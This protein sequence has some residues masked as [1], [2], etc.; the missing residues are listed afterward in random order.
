M[1]ANPDAL[2]RTYKVLL[3]A[4]PSSWRTQHGDELLGVL[5]DVAHSQDRERPRVKELA[6]LLVNGLLARVMLVV[7]TIPLNRRSRVAA[8]ATVVGAAA[9]ASMM[10]LGEV[11]R[12]FRW[13][14]YEGAGLFDPFTTAA[15]L[16]YLLTLAAFLATL[17][18]QPRIRIAAHLLTMTTCLA[19][20]WITEWT[21]TMVAPE[22][23][24]PVFFAATSALSL[25]ADPN[26]LRTGASA[27]VWMAPALAVAATLAAYRRGAGSTDSFYSPAHN[28]YDQVPLLAFFAIVLIL[29]VALLISNKATLPWVT[30]LAV[31]ALPLP[32]AFIGLAELNR[33]APYYI[34][35]G[36]AAAAA[37]WYVTK[38]PLLKSRDS[39]PAS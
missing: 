31:F 5:M 38:H 24:A 17:L 27:T 29:V 1:T 33:P 18:H 20:P 28:R 11:G 26:R 6:N 32:L 30:F 34:A 7:G 14:S 21:G 4:Y 19:L 3:N 9:A 22:W 37:A 8:G 39:H 15:S 12:W 13:N 2:K 35:S 10:I 25:L 36:I 23:Y 16:V